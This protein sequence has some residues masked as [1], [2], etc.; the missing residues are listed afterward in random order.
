MYFVT[1]M[2]NAGGGVHRVTWPGMVYIF[3]QLV[4]LLTKVYYY[5]LYSY[6]SHRL[7]LP[8]ISSP[9]VSFL[10]KKIEKWLPRPGFE[11]TTS[12]FEGEGAYHYTM[13]P[14]ILQLDIFKLLI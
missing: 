3:I 9:F 7:S 4:A 2:S 5:Q 6:I 8:H 1:F 14:L 12:R 10:G 11:H 13:N